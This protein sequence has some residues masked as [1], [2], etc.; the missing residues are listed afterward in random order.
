MH[1]RIISLGTNWWAMHCRDLDDPYCF[2][3][4]A[5]WFNS[6]GFKCGHRLRLNWIY[7]GQI[8]FNLTSGFDPEFRLRTIGKTFW[9]SGP[10]RHQGK[11]HLL[12]VRPA[13]SACPEM[14]LVTLN[15]AEHGPIQF[16]K[17]GWKSH[18]VEAISISLR[19]T[20]YEAMLL[21]TAESWIQSKCGRWQLSVDGRRLVLSESEGG[22]LR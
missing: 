18:D 14:Y 21:M 13:K 1:I 10:N 15:N 5:A 7:P 12:V 4:R 3:R 2:R 19:Q 8:R 22:D 11:V 9:C 16:G 17:P 20:R 6:T